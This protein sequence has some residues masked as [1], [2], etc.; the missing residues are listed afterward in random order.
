MRE[1]H[2]WHGDRHRHARDAAANVRPRHAAGSPRLPSPAGRLGKPMRL[3]TLDPERM[4]MS[5]D[6]QLPRRYEPEPPARR[7][8]RVPARRRTPPV[9]DAR[10]L[11]FTVGPD[12]EYWWGLISEK[13]RRRIE[14]KVGQRVEWWAWRHPTEKERPYAVVLG[15]NG[16]AVTTP[17]MNNAGRQAHLLRVRP[18]APASMRYSLIRQ[19][20]SGGPVP[21]RS[22][23]RVG[24]T[25]TDPRLPLTEGM[26]GFLGNLPIKAQAQLQK[27]FLDGDPV[28]DS[29]YYYYGTDERLNVWCYL[30]GA[31]TVTFASGFRVAPAG[32][33]PQAAVWDITCRAATVMM[34]R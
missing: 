1:L 19:E 17:T 22:G 20:P 21:S 14:Q 23:H 11:D 10:K 16:L 3:T 34:R 9:H 8:S 15:P 12:R 29:D 24:T 33:P 18:F 5:R 26:R 2:G 27:P 25:N 13:V 30:A 7:E 31:R 32:A 6:E 4:V 28:H